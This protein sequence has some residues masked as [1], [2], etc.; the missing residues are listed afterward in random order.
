MEASYTSK[1]LW[2][3][4]GL[5]G[6]SLGAVST[7]YLAI[8]QLLSFDGASVGLSVVGS[9]LS[10]ILWIAKFAGCILL[11]RYF[12][13]KF[14]ATFPG[15]DSRDKYPTI[16]S[17]TFGINLN[18]SGSADKAAPAPIRTT[19][20]DRGEPQVVERVVEKIVEK[21]VEV[22][23]EVVKEVRVPASATLDGTYEDDLYFV[24]GKSELRADEAFK[25][26][27]ICQILKDNPDAKITISGHAD[28]A[29]GSESINRSLSEERARVVVDKLTGAGIDASRITYSADGADRDSS[30][31]PESNRVAVCIV[32]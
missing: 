24:I 11:M 18:F 26:G 1:D 13:K 14:C 8:G 22:V 20:V 21:P 16:R 30:L 3:S 10:F 2:E 15:T 25:L 5:A 6:L 7:A 17:Y 28:T 12:M 4:A 23:K 19:Y 27:R 31:S 29:T 9:V 32:K